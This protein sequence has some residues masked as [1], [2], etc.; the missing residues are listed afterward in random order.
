MTTITT[1]KL[2]EIAHH[3]GLPVGVVRQFAFRNGVTI[4]DTPADTE[5]QT[6]GK[7]TITQEQLEKA[8]DIAG[9]D[10]Q[11][12]LEALLFLEIPVTPRRNGEAGAGGRD[13]E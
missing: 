4:D 9:A 2:R 11:N 1:A 6:M 3:L 8:A 7:M 12:M 10:K 5:E 13:A